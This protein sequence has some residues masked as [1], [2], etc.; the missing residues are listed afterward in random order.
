MALI[1]PYFLPLIKLGHVNGN[2]S[3]LYISKQ[4][5]QMFANEVQPN[6]PRLFVTCDKDN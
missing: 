6:L 4:T 5:S 1:P 2:I 3:L